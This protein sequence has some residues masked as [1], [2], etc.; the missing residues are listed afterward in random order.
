MNN[1]LRKA[2]REFSHD[3]SSQS[4][5]KRKLSQQGIAFFEFQDLLRNIITRFSTSTRDL[6]YLYV[7]PKITD[8]KYQLK[9]I[10]AEYFKFYIE[11]YLPVGLVQEKQIKNRQLYINY[12][13]HCLAYLGQPPANEQF[14]CQTTSTFENIG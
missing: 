12:A 3:I 10:F 4:I 11:N 7:R 9:L 8:P 14:D 6:L 1:I 5:V 2:A 13:R